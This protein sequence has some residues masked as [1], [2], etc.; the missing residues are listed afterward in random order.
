MQRKHGQKRNRSNGDSGGIAAVFIIGAAIVSAFIF[1]TVS[2]QSHPAITNNYSGTSVLPTKDSTL[3]TYTWSVYISK[4]NYITYTSYYEKATWHFGLRLSNGTI[5]QCQKTFV[6]NPLPI[7]FYTAYTTEIIEDNIGM[8][9]S[10]S[11]N[12]ERSL[13]LVNSITTL[14]D[15]KT[16]S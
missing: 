14:S 16:M 15:G 7:A 4:N 1:F 3:L 6:A 9:A 5:F 13:F 11:W 12:S 10:G 8:N 2:S